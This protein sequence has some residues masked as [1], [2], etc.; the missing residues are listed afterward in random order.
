LIRLLTLATGRR[1]W[2]NLLLAGGLWSICQASWADY[3]IQV[4]SYSKPFYADKTAQSLVEAG[5]SV[6]LRNTSG[7]NSSP[8]LQLLVGPYATRQVAEKDLGRLRSLGQAQDGFVRKY[9]T[10]ITVDKRPA[11]AHEA[12]PHP[13]AAVPSRPS[14]PLA[15]PGPSTPSSNFEERAE[16]SA[17]AV[18]EMPAATASPSPQ[19]PDEIDDLYGLD[20]EQGM[21]APRV[22][23]FFQSELA[24]AESSPE[25]L[26]KF[27]NTLELGAEGRF[28]SDITWKIS[29]RVAY[30]A[31]FDLNDYYSTAV[32]DDQ[33]FERSVR[34]TYT[35]ISAGNWD[36][37]LGRQQIIWGEMVGLFF[38]DVVS[39]KDL[40]EFVLPE[41]DT[42][43]IP[44]WAIRSEYFKGDFHGEAIWIPY[45][46]YDD[47]G[48]PG[49]EFYPYPTPPPPGYG[50]VITGEHRPAGSLADSNY[51]L[52]LSDLIN[53]WDVSGFY[54]SSMDSSPTFFRQV[55][56][57]PA[58]AFVYSPD[59][60]RIQQIGGTFSKAYA[61]T[62]LKAEM[63]YTLDRW[64]AVNDLSDIDGVV[65]K[66][67]LDYA[68]GL[69]YNLPHGS[70]LNFQFFQLWFPDYDP[71]MTA[72]RLES[73]ASFYASTKV[74][75]GNVEPQ[76]L[77]IASLSRGDWMARPK[78]VWTL[79][80][81]WR[82]VI[83]ADLFDGS[84]TGLFGQYDGK[85]RIYT[86][87]RYIF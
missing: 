37:R 8:M 77:V 84:R 19:K 13:P 22:T 83:G 82:W 25:H 10:D 73:G 48:V 5:F 41:F 85:D 61:D 78:V 27:R 74:M 17:P 40:R 51:G 70:R 71:A 63:V 35:D 20:V 16:T 32:R 30:D 81:N 60:K 34:E 72:K 12:V 47:I 38:A 9:D 62:V 24:Y 44:Q 39:A 6:G 28:T 33:Q 7:A 1:F 4:A 64:F 15:V 11:L 49:S 79:N 76:L 80:G 67:N 57:T 43:R 53:G 55:V 2:L 36:F 58:P 23:G 54:Y 42:L 46:T 3:W 66:D 26:S 65:Q 14:L 45:P 69:D 87:V 52:R 59:H 18:K 86:E 21:S 56:T 68:V 75:D 31:V 50:M 29:G